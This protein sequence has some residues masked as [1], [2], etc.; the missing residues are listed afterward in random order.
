M[1]FAK[2]TFVLLAVATCFTVLLLPARR[3]AAE[4]IGFLRSSLSVSL[5]E[6]DP[7]YE[8][9]DR[10]GTFLLAP[11]QRIQALGSVETSYVARTWGRAQTS[12]TRAHSAQAVAQ[13]GAE[14]ASSNPYGIYG[15]AH[16][17]AWAH[18]VYEAAIV[19]TSTPPFPPPAIPINFTLKVGGYA[20]GQAAWNATASVVLAETAQQVLYKRYDQSTWILSPPDPTA[21]FPSVPAATDSGTFLVG[22]SGV[23]YVILDADCGATTSHS[24]GVPRSTCGAFID[25]VFSFNQELFDQ[26]MGEDTYNLADYFEFVLTPVPV[27]MFSPFLLYGLLPGLL[28]GTGV[29]A[30]RRRN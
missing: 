26:E 14:T 17:D 9:D 11:G 20:L 3:S 5:N 16:A 13:A 2:R 18:I 4:A 10:D 8:I 30:M 15:S 21:D 19:G 25:P 24:A 27:P 22:G 6:P 28:A 12:Y 29:V 7:Q 1:F 23:A